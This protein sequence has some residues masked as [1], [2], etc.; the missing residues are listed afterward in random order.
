MNKGRVR[1]REKGSW[2]RLEGRGLPYLNAVGSGG[3]EQGGHER[4]PLDVAHFLLPEV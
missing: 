1:E 2:K 3:E 4:V